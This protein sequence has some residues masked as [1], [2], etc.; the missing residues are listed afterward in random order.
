MESQKIYLTSEL[1]I[2]LRAYRTSPK[3]EAEIKEQ[4]KNLLE[5]SLIKE[6]CSPYLAPVT[7]MLKG[8]RKKAWFCIDFCKLNAITKTDAEP[9]P[10]IDTLLDK[11]AKARFFSTLDF[12]NEYWHISYPPKRHQK[13]SI[14]HPIWIIWVVGFTFQISQCPCHI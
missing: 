10:R 5:T 12:A 2:S 1:P 9:F 6:S 11:L 7:L 14:C 8:E 3:K 13:I 4:V